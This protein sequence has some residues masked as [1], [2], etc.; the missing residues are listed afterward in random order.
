MTISAN[1]VEIKRS[2]YP[3]IADDG[4]VLVLMTRPKQGV[5]I[6]NSRV[7]EELK[8]D[9]EEMENNSYNIG[10]FCSM[11]REEKFTIFSGEVTLK[12]EF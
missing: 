11:W 9:P 6:D 7:S 3:Y 10:D 2:T 5:V 8:N 12:N 4:A 1:H